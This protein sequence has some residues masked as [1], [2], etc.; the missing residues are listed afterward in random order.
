MVCC[1]FELGLFELGCT[2]DRCGSFSKVSIV[3]A[4][5]GCDSLLVVWVASGLVVVMEGILIV[6]SPLASLAGV[7]LALGQGCFSR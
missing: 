6:S 4:V 3:F 1:G 2:R 7:P 5:L